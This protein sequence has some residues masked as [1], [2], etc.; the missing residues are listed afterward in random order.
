MV[1]T[2][3][4]IPV[5]EES[6]R[7]QGPAVVEATWLSAA[8]YFG[9]LL[10]L[11]RGLF[12]AGLL[13]QFYFGVWTSMRM[14][15]DL[16]RY[17]SLGAPEGMEQLAPY[18]RVVDGRDSADRLRSG[19]A[20]IVLVVA[21]LAAFWIGGIGLRPGSI[22]AESWR[23]EWIVFAGVFI[24]AQFYLF[25]LAA[26][27]TLH[28]FRPISLISVTATASSLLGLLAIPRW[29][30]IGFLCV[31]GAAYGLGILIATRLSGVKPR[32]VPGTAPRL[33]AHGFPIMSAN[34]LASLQWHLDKIFIWAFMG[35][36][37][38]GVYAL[39]THLVN[40]VMIFPR[41]V[42]AVM[43]PRLRERQGTMGSLNGEYSELEKLTS[44]LGH[45]VLPT[46]GLLWIGLEYL[47]LLALPRYSSAV[48]PGRLLLLG[49]Y[50][51]VLA[52]LTTPIL[53]SHGGQ[54]RLIG[55]RVLGLVVTSLGFYLVQRTGSG[56]P[57]VAVATAAGLSAQAGAAVLFSLDV[58]RIPRR[59]SFRFLARAG[60]GF[61]GLAVV[62]F[63]LVGLYPAPSLREVSSTDVIISASLAVG[64][65]IWLILTIRREMLCR[66]FWLHREAS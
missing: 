24:L 50:L 27:R 17:L 25:N 49:V 13:G 34:L 45:L 33:I 56:L 35:F 23:P 64:M 3:S 55:S 8:N 46:L 7:R 20:G 12:L 63:G 44:F 31:L 5:D 11:I 14:V 47:V 59:D 38:L 18:A 51:P 19:A 9:Q 16:G 6:P 58:L 41:N 57:F 61:V 22:A 39:S 60:V 42:A 30:L 37:D 29:G 15:R 48:V 21:A 32:L 66:P 54:R 62:L 28:A 10:F 2:D 65:L 26:L 53:I 40:A 36:S 43:Y 52:G 4:S 1:E